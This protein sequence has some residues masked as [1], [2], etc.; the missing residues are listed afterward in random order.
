M[1][2]LRF[3]RYGEPSEV[4]ALENSDIPSPAAGR[5]LIAVHACGLNPADWALCRGLF[6]GNLP[7]GVGLDVSGIVEKVGEGVTDTAPG[8]RVLGVADYAGAPCAGAGEYA[9]CNHWAGAPEGLDFVAAAALPMAVE[10]AFRS[11]DWLGV[12]AHH[13][14][15]VN[16]AGTMVGFAAVQIARLKGATVI[17]TSGETYAA[18]LRAFGAMVVAYG[19][20]LASRVRDT[21]VSPD[22]VFDAGPP[23]G[24]LPELV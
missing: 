3:H 8:D 14:L 19:E 12:E 23:A 1:K 22:L 6:P 15:L 10:T 5:I 18:Q 7:R 20:G 2:T 9:I 24:I 16:G 13:T 21:G 4:L 11:L 17:A